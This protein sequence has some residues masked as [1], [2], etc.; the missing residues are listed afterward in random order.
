MIETLLVTIQPHR[1]SIETKGEAECGER[2][3]CQD[4]HEKGNAMPSSGVGRLLDS[5]LSKLVII[6]AVERLI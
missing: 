4:E 3:R 1:L 5:S 2:R 6:I